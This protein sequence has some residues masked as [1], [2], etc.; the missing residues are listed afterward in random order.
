MT[1]LSPDHG[2]RFTILAAGNDTTAVVQTLTQAMLDILVPAL[3]AAAKEEAVLRFTGTY[4]HDKSNSS[5]T[6]TTDGGPG[7]KVEEWINES[8][9]MIG[10]IQALE[11]YSSAPS[12]RLYPTGLESL[13]QVSFVAIIQQLESTSTQVPCTTWYMVDSQVYGNVG[14]DE[15]LFEV[16]G[17]GDAVALSPRVLRTVLPKASSKR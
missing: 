11:S 12:V 14:V 3:D 1:A 4:A 9:D 10:T 17:Q 13:G 2:I 8:V 5:I 7:L 6:I 15:F 16:D